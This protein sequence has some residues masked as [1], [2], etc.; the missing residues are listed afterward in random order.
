M[1]V[2]PPAPRASDHLVLPVVDLATARSR[3]SDLGFSVAPEAL[4]PFGTENA[5]V[6]FADGGYLEPLAV[7]SR[8]DCE[9]AAKAGNVFV[10]RDQAFRFRCGEGLSAIVAASADAADDHARYGREGFSAGDM[11]SFARPMRLPDGS[12]QMAAFD[13]A[14]AADLRAPDFFLFSCQR[15]NTLPVD[16]ASLT[17]HANGATGLSSVVI[18]EENPSDFQYLLELVFDQRDVA[19]H[20][21]GIEIQV[22]N[23]RIEVLTPAGLQGFYGLSG[24]TTERGLRGRVVVMR[25]ADRGVTEKLLA[26]KGVAFNVVANRLV[27]PPQPGQGVA[28]AFEETA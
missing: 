6:F 9:A 5:C 21:F 28:F 19:A 18:C 3:L 4:H 27:V 23:G 11:L 17:T 10:A 8:E 13:L 26:D 15:R 14:F 7:A 2:S 12:E 16:R 1:S 25:V 22:A 24:D 20:S